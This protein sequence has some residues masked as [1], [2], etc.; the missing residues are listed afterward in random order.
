MKASRD[1]YD[2]PLKEALGQYL[3]SFL[4]LCFP[5]VSQAIDWNK[6]VEFLDKEL[7][8]VVRDASAGKRHV[9]KLVKVHLKSGAATLDPA[10][11]GSAAS[12]GA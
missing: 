6:K 12:G 10:S 5:Q 11:F 8:E 3:N 7:Q 2:S 1:Q 9:Y 4:N